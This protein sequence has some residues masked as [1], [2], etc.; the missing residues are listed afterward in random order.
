VDHRRLGKSGLE[1]LAIGMGCFGMSQ[2]YGRADDAESTETIH[3]ALDL[4]VNFLDPAD[5]YGNGQNEELVGRALTGRRDQV[6]LA[7]KF[8]NVRLPDGTTGL[9]GRPE[10]VAQACDASLQRLQVS[11]LDVYFLHRVDP[12]VPIEDTVGAM[13]RLIE[14][15]KVR[16]LGLSEVAPATLRRAHATYPIAALQSEYSLWTRDVEAE[17]L[18]TCRELGIGYVAH[19]PLGRGFLGGTIRS[20]ETLSASDHRRDM[21]RY[22]G[23]NLARNLRLLQALEAFAAAKACSPAQIALAWL[24]AQGEDIVPIPGTKRRGFLE[25]N[26]K[27]AGLRLS[28]EEQKRLGALFPPG[29]AA[30][31]RLPP[32]LM[33]RVGG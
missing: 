20:R 3:R 33:K 13:G 1:V 4:G 25:E 29:A 32:A 15:G 27:A 21:P 5:I 9:N 17:I 22:E 18:P 16:H 12:G 2:V 7:T 14:Q 26:A 31:E 8:G 19:A 10:Y 11:W 23:E 28:S 24:L 6:V 30:G